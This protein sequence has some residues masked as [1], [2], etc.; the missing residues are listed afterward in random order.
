MNRDELH[1]MIR[2]DQAGEFGATRI[3]EGQIAVMGD[4]GPH[5]AEI[6]HMAEQEE[7]HRARFDEMLVARGVRPT[8]LHPFWSAAGYA[9]GAGTALLGPEAAMACTAAVEEEIDKHYS[10]QLDRLTETGADP[11]LAEMIEEFREDERQHRDA[12]LANGAEQAPAYPLLA[13]AIKLGCRI[14][15]K[16]S[17]RI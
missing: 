12:A 8:A 14:A 3:Y 2:V 16:V 6:R 17:E 13:G 10:E 4:R 7:G 11:E 9:L 1:R 15:I 5:S